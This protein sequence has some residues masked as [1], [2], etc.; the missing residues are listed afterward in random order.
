M[1]LASFVSHAE[2]RVCV[3]HVSLK[4]SPSASAHRQGPLPAKRLCWG[5]GALTQPKDSAWHTEPG[6]ASEHSSAV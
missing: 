2:K 6:Q 4:H 5:L 1:R 3:S